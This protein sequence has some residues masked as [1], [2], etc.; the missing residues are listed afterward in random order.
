M[1]DAELTHLHQRYRA[2][3][4]QIRQLGFIA[5]GSVIQRYTV[6]GGRGLLH[7]QAA[8]FV[9]AP[10]A[11]GSGVGSPCSRMTSRCPAIASRVLTS[12][13]SVRSR[14]HRVA[15]PNVDLD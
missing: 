9:N 10:T 4:D 2:L 7:G 3:Q 6:C 14:R 12:G 1:T 11:D 15:R 13:C 5:P 8:S